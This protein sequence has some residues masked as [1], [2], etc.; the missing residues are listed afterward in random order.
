VVIVTPRDVQRMLAATDGWQ[1][2]LCLAVL[3]YLGHGATLQVG[4]V[5]ATST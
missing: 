1:E 3:A 4:F 5:G 2:F